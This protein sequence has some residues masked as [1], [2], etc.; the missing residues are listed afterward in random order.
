VGRDLHDI[1]AR[2]VDVEIKQRRIADIGDVSESESEDDV[3]H[4]EEEIAV[5]DAANERLIR[6]VAR[7]AQEP[8]WTF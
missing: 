7:R 5:E 2:L 3:G 1:R 6:V 8:K 4:E